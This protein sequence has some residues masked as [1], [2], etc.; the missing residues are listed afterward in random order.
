MKWIW[1]RQDKLEKPKSEVVQEEKPKAHV[2]GWVQTPNSLAISGLADWSCVSCTPSFQSI[3]K[4]DVTLFVFQ[5]SLPPRLL[6]FLWPLWLLWLFWLLCLLRLLYIL[7]FLPSCFLSAL[8]VCWLLVP[9]FGF[10]DFLAVCCN[11][12]R[13][14]SKTSNQS[15]E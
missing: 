1:L 10:C 6:W 13:T 5:C 12:V 15:D 9:F 8:V 11:Y 14:R 4:S 3:G 7:G 2:V